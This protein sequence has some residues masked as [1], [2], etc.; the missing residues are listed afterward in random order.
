MG[1][2][3]TITLQNQI[4]N[5]ED[6]KETEEDVIDRPFNRGAIQGTDIPNL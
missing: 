2:P 1:C 5:S 3:D 6:Q 4:G